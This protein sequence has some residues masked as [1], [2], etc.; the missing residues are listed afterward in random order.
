MSSYLESLMEERVYRKKL[1]PA[2]RHADL[3]H[4]VKNAHDLRHRNNMP[5][6]QTLDIAA[7]KTR[8]PYGSPRNE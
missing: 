5:F 8:L 4:I 2:F 1:G 6:D 7:G 3:E